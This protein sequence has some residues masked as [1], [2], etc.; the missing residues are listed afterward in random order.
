MGR[1]A[2]ALVWVGI[3]LAAGYDSYFAWQ[4]RA[5]FTAWEQNPLACWAAAAF[6]LGAVLVFKF[7][8]LTFA[9]GL[10][11]Y[12]RGRRPHLEAPITV[13]IGAAYGLLVAHYAISSQQAS[14]SPL[15]A[16]APVAWPASR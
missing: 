1:T 5:V 13:I 8:G 6:G 14:G 7:V 9:A 12:C 15:A 16:R 4:Y 10:A 11:C 3:F 2:F